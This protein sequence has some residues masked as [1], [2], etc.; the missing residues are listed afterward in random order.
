[1]DTEYESLI[2]REKSLIRFQAFT[3]PPPSLW[4]RLLSVLRRGYV[5]VGLLFN[6]FLFF[7]WVLYLSSF[8]YV[9]L[10]AFSSF[11]IMRKRELVA[12]LLLSF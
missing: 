8:C 6:V 2:Y 11:A 5:V 4:L 7:V 9:L 10:C 12:L 1:M 3:P